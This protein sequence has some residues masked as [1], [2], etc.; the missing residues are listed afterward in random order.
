MKKASKKIAKKETSTPQAT[1]PPQSSSSQSQSSSLSSGVREGVA[2]RWAFIGLAVV[3]LVGIVRMSLDAGISGDET[4]HYKHAADVYSYYMSG[5][6]D[7]TA[8]TLTQ[9]NNMPSYGQVVDN[10]AFFVEK[11]FHVEDYMVVR[12]VINAI[13]G[14]LAMLFASL[15]AFRVGRQWKAAILTL[16]L[17]FFSPRFLGH[18]FNNLKDLPLATGMVMG[19]YYII[20]FLQDFPRVKK[21]TAIMLAVSIGFSIAVR[22]GGLLL[23]AYFGLFCAVLFIK[24]YTLRGIWTKPGSLLFGKMLKWGLIVV[25]AGYALAMLLW[26][27]GLVSPI[28]HPKFVLSYMSQF[29]ISIRQNFEGRMIWSSELPLYYTVKFILMTIPVA[30][31]AGVVIYLFAGGLKKENR[32]ETFM[33]Y[34]AFIFPIFWITYTKANVYGGWRHSMFSYPPMAVA[35]GLGFN[36]LINWA[37]QKV[38]KKLQVTDVACGAVGVACVLGLLA[39]PIRHV[40]SNHPYEYVYFN[41]LAG[42]MK[43]AFG[44]YELDYYYHS[45]REA[46]EWIKSDVAKNGAPDSTRKTKVVT[47]HTMSVS[48]CFRNDTAD[49]AVGFARWYERGYGDWDYAIFVITGINPEL[50]KNKSAFPPKNTAYQIKVDGKPICLVLKR[51]D[52]S[53]YYGHRAMQQGQ[54]G[55]AVAYLQKALAYDSYNEQALDDLI[56]I[57]SQIQMP[58]SALTLAR[59]WA[60]FNR[61]SSAALVHMANLY[62]NRGDLSNALLTA[63]AITKLN[64]RDISGLW[65]AAN[66]YARE[67]NAN[68]AL[69]NLNTI[70]QM[71]SNF[72]P[73]YQLMA[74]LYSK[75]GNR[76]QAQ[77]IIEAMNSLP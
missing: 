12:H 42:G 69:K 17:L 2:W 70:L 55:E 7:T 74:E 29:A 3:A 30:V 66:V 63:N 15:I 51:E 57:Y 72:K 39:N 71:R 16:L 25:V 76:Q 21:S 31:I 27:Y 32:F 68:A 10:I 35:A 61:G 46:S 26:P 40:I 50:Q 77:R 44:N 9:Q 60:K 59:H 62:F 34:F 41:E 19:L 49:F 38:K 22:I 6:K 28:E 18:S 13:C 33:I 47:W 1:P 11:I 73:A 8:V 23:I 24:N 58:D 75:A 14:W 5:G 45:T 67:N 56:Q 64:S 4:Y 54:V 53:D 52:K 20:V 36:A 43:K 65:I 37:A 48:Y